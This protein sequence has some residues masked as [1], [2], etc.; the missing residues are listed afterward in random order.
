MDH[1]MPREPIPTWFFSLV[2]VQREDRFLLV[3]ERKHDQMWYLPA[4]RVEPGET[5]AAA[6]I[7][8]TLE[9]TGIPVR[10]V[11]IVRVEHSPALSHSRMRVFFLAEPLDD[12]PPKS[13]PDEESLGATWVRLDELS[14]FPLRGDEVRELFEYVAMG[15]PVYSLDVLQ[16]EGAPF[17]GKKSTG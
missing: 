3:Q 14:K 6:A 5:L 13:I 1:L 12:S 17:P 10:L 2:V 9:E 11:G 8:E 4:G 7:R 16:R 15:G